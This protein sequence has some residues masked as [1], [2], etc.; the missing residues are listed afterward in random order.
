M[1][2]AAKNQLSGAHPVAAANLSPSE[3]ALYTR[4]LLESLR[5]IAMRQ[6]QEVLAQLLELARYEA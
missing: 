2:Q 3:S 4:E 5:K 6:N 1:T